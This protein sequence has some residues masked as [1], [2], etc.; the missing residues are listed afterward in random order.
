MVEKGLFVMIPGLDLAMV[1]W[2][3]GLIWGKEYLPL[4][5]GVAGSVCCLA[6]SVCYYPSSSVYS[7]AIC[8]LFITPLQS[9]FAK[10]RTPQDTGTSPLPLLTPLPFLSPLSYCNLDPLPSP[11]LSPLLL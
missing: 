1:G 10:Q 8:S 5:L 9:S 11:L 7:I 4:A 2:V 3:C 6:T